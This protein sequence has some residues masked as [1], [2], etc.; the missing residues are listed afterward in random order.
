MTCVIS[1]SKTGMTCVMDRDQLVDRG[2]RE[3]VKGV[4]TNPLLVDRDRQGVGGTG[5][6]SDGP[7]NGSKRGSETEKKRA[8][9]KK[10]R[11]GSVFTSGNVR[12]GF[13]TP[14]ITGNP[15]VWPLGTLLET[16]GSGSLGT[17]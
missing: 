10:L 6:G 11:R 3:G 14:S 2:Q 5:G 9:T 1:R 13:W 15:L 17:G 16:G 7:G 12:T 4:G 8:R